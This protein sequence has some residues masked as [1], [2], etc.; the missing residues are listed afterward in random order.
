VRL[1]RARCVEALSIMAKKKKSY[2]LSGFTAAEI[3]RLVAEKLEVAPSISVCVVWA[4]GSDPKHY[5]VWITEGM[6][7]A[8]EVG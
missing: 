1:S 3:G 2:T 5:K 4:L 8:M 7:G 6:S